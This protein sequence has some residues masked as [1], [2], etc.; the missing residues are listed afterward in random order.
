M[1]LMQSIYKYSLHKKS[2]KHTCPS[3]G[4]KRFVRY[5]NNENNQFLSDK[6]GRCDREQSCGYHYTP[7]HYFN[8]IKKDYTPFI[9]STILQNRTQQIISFHENKELKL[10]LNN[11]DKNNFVQFLKFKI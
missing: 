5:I 8:D 9:S 11:Y 7:K 1:K 6:V 2:T 4:E 10:S 3:C